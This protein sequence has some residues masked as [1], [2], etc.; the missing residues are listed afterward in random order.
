MEYVRTQ[1]STEHVRSRSAIDQKVG[2]INTGDRLTKGHLRLSQTEDGGTVYGRNGGQC[3][4]GVVDERV[5]PC[6]GGIERV[7]D[8]IADAAVDIPIS[9]DCPSSR[10]GE[11][12]NIIRAGAVDAGSRQTVDDEI[13]GLNAN[14][15]FAERDRELRKAADNCA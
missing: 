8:Q 3:G 10:L 6:P 5:S 1:A 15:I 2:G 11:G 7:A 4:S 9:H 14:D 12:E 13:L